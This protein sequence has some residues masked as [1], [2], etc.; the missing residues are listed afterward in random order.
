MKVEDNVC[1]D[2]DVLWEV[3]LIDHFVFET[4]HVAPC[5]SFQLQD[6]IPAQE[7]IPFYLSLLNWWILGLFAMFCSSSSAVGLLMTL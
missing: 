3:D 7:R 4:C 6:H 2:G 1:T 5:D